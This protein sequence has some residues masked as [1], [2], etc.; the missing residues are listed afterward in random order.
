M[1]ARKIYGFTLEQQEQI[2]RGW[3]QGESF[4]DIGRLIGK[5]PGCIHPVI[6]YY[7]GMSPTPQKRS[8]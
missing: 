1:Q 5:A 3:K 7:G 2:W 6:G 4:S 8:D